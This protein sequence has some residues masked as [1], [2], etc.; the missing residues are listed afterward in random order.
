MVDT[1]NR[2]YE[3]L[4][5][6]IGPM[7][8][9]PCIRNI[10]IYANDIPIIMKPIPFLNSPLYICPRPGKINDA[11]TAIIGF[12]FLIAALVFIQFPLTHY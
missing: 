10:Q 5:T 2:R 9:R 11:I 3:A 1:H 12:F 7:I 4:A 8:W 6:R